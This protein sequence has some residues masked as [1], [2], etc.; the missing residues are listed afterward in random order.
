LAQYD[1][2]VPLEPPSS[3]GWPPDKI[4][5][6]INRLERRQNVMGAALLIVAVLALVVALVK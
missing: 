1:R 4:V 3:A 2:V 6:A 5:D